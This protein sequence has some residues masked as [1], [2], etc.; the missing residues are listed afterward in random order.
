MNHK[1]EREL[2]VAKEIAYEAGAIMKEYFDKNQGIRDKDD[3]SAVTVADTMINT[4]VIRRLAKSFPRDGVVGE[5]ES[6]ADYGE[7]RRWICDPIDGT[8]AFVTGVPTPMFSLALVVDGKPMVGVCFSP[9][10]D[11]LYYATDGGG[12]YCNDKEIKVSNE[13]LKGG[14]L[15]VTNSIEKMRQN[16]SY[17]DRILDKKIKFASVNGAVFKGCLVA[18]GRAVAYVGDKINPYDVVAVHIITEEA[19]GKVTGFDGQALDYTKNFSN[20][21]VSNGVVHAEVLGLINHD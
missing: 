4:L 10:L 15:M 1:W 19:G 17:I 6:T 5:E 13:G 11:K 14:I 2:E 7:G 3:G 18:G 20:A 16:N 21:L 9:V 12:A 8:W